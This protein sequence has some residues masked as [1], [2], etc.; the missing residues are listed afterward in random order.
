MW[1]TVHKLF[2]ILSISTSI[3][4]FRTSVSCL[5]FND[6]SLTTNRTRLSDKSICITGSRSRGRNSS[7][8]SQSR[9]RRRCRNFR[10]CFRLLFFGSTWFT[11][12]LLRFFLCLF[13]RLGNCLLNSDTPVRIIWKYAHHDFRYHLLQFFEE[14]TGIVS[15]LFN[16]T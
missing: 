4:P 2:E 13:F 16:L 11:L 8:R 9:R 1:D 15:L 3:S 7:R 10:F 14:L 5:P 12:T 6:G